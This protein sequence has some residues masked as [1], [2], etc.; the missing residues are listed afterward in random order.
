MIVVDKRCEG[1]QLT[2]N[3]SFVQNVLSPFHGEI[4]DD[5]ISKLTT[6]SLA[7]VTFV[8]NWYASQY[9]IYYKSNKWFEIKRNFFNSTNIGDTYLRLKV[10]GKKWSKSNV[11]YLKIVNYVL[12]WTF[13]WVTP[14]VLN[15][16]MVSVHL[17][18]SCYFKILSLK[19]L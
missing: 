14:Q 13:F 5:M 16:L 18:K 9:R 1:R 8:L 17:Y 15:H 10:M 6:A 3:L 2:K 4:N 11:R 7:F 19:R 12:L